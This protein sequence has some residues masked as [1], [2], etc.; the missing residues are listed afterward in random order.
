MPS[1]RTAISVR[2]CLASEICICCLQWPIGTW[3]TGL[4]FWREACHALDKLVVCSAQGESTHHKQYICKHNMC[5]LANPFVLQ[6]LF[7][8]WFRLFWHYEKNPALNFHIYIY[9]SSTWA[10]GAESWP[11]GECM[12]SSGWIW[13][14]NEGHNIFMKKILMQAVDLPNG[15]SGVSPIPCCQG[16]N[17]TEIAGG[18][19]LVEEKTCTLLSHIKSIKIKDQQAADQHVASSIIRTP[20]SQEHLDY[21]PNPREQ[22]IEDLVVIGGKNGDEIVTVRHFTGHIFTN[23]ACH[24][25]ICQ[26]VILLKFASASCQPKVAFFVSV[27][28]NNLQVDEL[29]AARH[30]DDSG[31]VAISLH[32]NGFQLCPIDADDKEQI[33]RLNTAAALVPAHLLSD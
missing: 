13:P 32:H 27:T 1:P 7:A 24:L 5:I 23:S 10:F 11:E 4:C 30:L 3:C 12:E 26:L 8:K 15:R 20:H 28:V 25:S 9:M 16:K 17:V 22:Q 14:C 6:T 29:L 31:L 19:H 21:E 18:S 2:A 33:K